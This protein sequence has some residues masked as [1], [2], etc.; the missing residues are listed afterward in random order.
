MA[1][2]ETS[3]RTPPNEKFGM[4][5]IGLPAVTSSS[6]RDDST[7]TAS[8]AGAAADGEPVGEPDSHGF[9]EDA[10]EPAALRVV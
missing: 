6:I 1:S 7:V 4:L 9:A 8:S 2:T 3:G 5:V 10:L